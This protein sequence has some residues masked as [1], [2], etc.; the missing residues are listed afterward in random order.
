MKEFKFIL[1]FLTI[2]SLAQAQ[3]FNNPSK[4]ELSYKDIKENIIIVSDKTLYVTNEVLNYKASYL[5]NRNLEDRQWSR[6]LYV[7]LVNENG[8]PVVQD[9][10]KLG[11]DGAANEM[12][13]PRNINSGVYYLKAYTQ[14]M[15]NDFV[16]NYGLAEVVVINPNNN[17]P[18]HLNNNT[19]AS[20]VDNESLS[21]GS[22]VEFELS[23]KIFSKR[24]TVNLEIEYK[25]DYSNQYDH[26]ITV[27]K[28]GTLLQNKV[29]L[30]GQRPKEKKNIQYLP[31]FY[32][33][34]LSGKLLY[35]DSQEPYKNGTVYI[36][37]LNNG[38]FMGGS[39]INE[40]GEFLFSLPYSY[41]ETDF[42]LSTSEQI[43]NVDI[44][45]NRAY[46]SEQITFEKSIFSFD[47]S[48]IDELLINQQLTEHYSHKQSVNNS[49]LKLKR[50]FY[51]S[52]KNT[53]Y[54]KDFVD[55]PHLEEFIFEIVPDVTV[56]YQDKKPGIRSSVWNAFSSSPFLL[57][58]DNIP[59]L[60]IRQFLD[61][62]TG[63]VK[64][65]DI[66]NESYLLGNLKYAGI[67]N[68]FS[69]RNDLAGLELP[70]NSTFISYEMLKP[71]SKAIGSNLFNENANT[72]DLRN[73]LYWNP[74]ISPTL[75]S[76]SNISFTTSDIT[77]EFE[78]VV[79]SISKADGQMKTHKVDFVVE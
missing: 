79:F 39:I 31:D 2:I 64:K 58:V 25:D 55:L 60:D 51:G 56:F 43:E 71:S 35:K 45:T 6:V 23:G 42:Y 66:L 70:R 40:D 22:F 50:P 7:E 54:T 41:N 67:I 12:L 65:V 20:T 27:V 53:Y 4:V 18:I 28:K 61:I 34:N 38:P 19:Q 10:V 69:K 14:W 8:S 44:K 29:K 63:S 47:K 74:W 32:G 33:L 52:P 3:N 48:L 59:I 49:S 26:I 57:M 11:L 78:I 15:R 30:K 76:S 68:V 17:I 9:K 37:A 77:G 46:C 72:P 73:C 5:C 75:N 13:I 36:S 24:D 62:K 21:Q 16:D 1:L